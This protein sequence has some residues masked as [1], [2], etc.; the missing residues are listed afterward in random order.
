MGFFASYKRLSRKAKIILGL[1]GVA[2]GL[3]G[4]YIVPL[5]P[6]TDIPEE[7]L[8]LN[9]ETVRETAPS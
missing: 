7:K 9:E 1:V 3:V 8:S 2:I 5:L 6:A 4:P